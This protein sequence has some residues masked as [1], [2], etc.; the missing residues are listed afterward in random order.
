MV[1]FE[2]L[3]VGV[4]RKA[5]DPDIAGRGIDFVSG[6]DRVDRNVVADDRKFQR[7]LLPVPYNLQVD[8]SAFRAAQDFG[9][10][11]LLRADDI[12]AVR[13]HN[14]VVR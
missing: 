12:L 3:L 10:V 7:S 8:A 14:P 5:I 1:G 13:L 9:H 2:E 6:V 11:E 4:V